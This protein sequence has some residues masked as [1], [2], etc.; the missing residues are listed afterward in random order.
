MSKAAEAN[1]AGAFD[2][3]SNV[4]EHPLHIANIAQSMGHASNAQTCAH[5]FIQEWQASRLK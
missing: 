2:I 1:P 4:Q 3:N 5:A